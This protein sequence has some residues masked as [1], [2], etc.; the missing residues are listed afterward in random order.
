MDSIT[1][2]AE[3]AEQ[4]GALSREEILKSAE[5]PYGDREPPPDSDWDYIRTGASTDWER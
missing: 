1:C 2:S 4:C 3:V 5:R